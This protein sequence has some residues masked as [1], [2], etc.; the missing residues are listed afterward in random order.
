[1][2]LE[3]KQELAR[4]SE[5]IEQVLTRLDKIE[6]QDPTSGVNQAKKFVG[7]SKLASR[8]HP[9]LKVSQGDLLPVM[10]RTDVFISRLFTHYSMRCAVWR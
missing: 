2:L 7:H 8:D 1:M 6:A 4:H 5:L 10:P 3:F 9:A